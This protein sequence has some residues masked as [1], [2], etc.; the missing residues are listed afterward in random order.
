VPPHELRPEVPRTISAIVLRALERDPRARYQSAGELA[1]DLRRAARESW[2]EPPQKR[3]LA[4]F[5]ERSGGEELDRLQ[6]L[7]RLGTEGAAPEAIEAVQP[8]VTRVLSEDASGVALLGTGAR[9][10]SVLDG[11][12]EEEDEGQPTVMIVTDE[13]TPSERATAMAL[14]TP[15]AEADLFEDE[16]PMRDIEAE[17]TD[18]AIAMAA[19][20]PPDPP[21]TEH[22][23]DEE[24]PSIIT[25]VSARQPVHGATT[26]T[27]RPRLPASAVWIAGVAIFTAL[28][29]GVGSAIVLLLPDDEQSA[30]L[31]IS[32]APLP[33]AIPPIATP[34]VV[35]PAIPPVAPVPAI[36]IPPVEIAEPRPEPPPEAIAVPEEP[37]PR[38]VEAPRRRRRSRTERSPSTPQPVP[39]A[40]P[41]RRT[42][43][44]LGV[45]DFDRRSR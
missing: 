10:T 5:V 19:D 32:P 11:D 2:G 35:P 27:I 1:L 44:L 18:P 41:P 7:I 3:E 17:R 4:Q 15:E 6:R 9:R 23:R 43:T 29:F 21:T 14:R 37:E 42:G 31:P 30:V 12:V 8:G 33:A 45:Q 22:V 39:V 16:T 40:E 36:A 25:S 34:A 38:R 28:S 26:D 24:P 13:L 20:T